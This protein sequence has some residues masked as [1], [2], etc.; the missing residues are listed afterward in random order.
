L[1]NLIRLDGFSRE[2]VNDMMVGQKIDRLWWPSAQESDQC[3]LI[4][5]ELKS[6]LNM[7]FSSVPTLLS[8]WTEVGVLHIERSDSDQGLIDISKTEVALGHD[9]ISVGVLRISL[10]G[11]IFECGIKFN[12][13]NNDSFIFL[14]GVAP[15]SL[16]IGYESLSFYPNPECPIGDYRESSLP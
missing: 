11:V 9:I 6:G 1:K 7:I 10:E 5:L 4:G 13:D 14:P 2:D 12:L 16:T 3:W 15:G 8:G